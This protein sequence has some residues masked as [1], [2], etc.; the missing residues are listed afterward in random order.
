MSGTSR[1]STR[2]TIRLPNSVVRTLESR[3]ASPRSHW[4][5][6]EDYIKERLI[7]DTERKHDR[8]RG[9]K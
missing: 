4:A 1:I 3:I 9:K 7:Y 2:I 8:K 6:V 5:S